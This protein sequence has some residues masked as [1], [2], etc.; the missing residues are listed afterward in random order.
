M[1]TPTP[2]SQTDKKTWIIIGGCLFVT[3]CLLCGIVLAVAAFFV[4]NRS[5]LPITMPTPTAVPTAIIVPTATPLLPTP[6]IHATP[7]NAP[8]PLPAT[9]TQPES[10]NLN[11]PAEVE[12]APIPELAFASLEQLYNGNY[13][14]YD[15]FEVAERL[16]GRDYGER[17][18]PQP[19]FNVGDKRMFVTDN[20]EHEATLLLATENAYFWAE[21]TLQLDMDK[22][23]QVADR[24]E[25]R[26][27]PQLVYLFGQEWRPGIDN[28]P[29]FNIMHLDTEGGS[30]L[31]YF[32]STDVYPKTLFSDSNEMEVIYLNMGNLSLGSE[33]YDGTLVHE[34]QHMI[35]WYVD[36]NET[37]W[38][39]E[40]LSQLAE[41]YLG[42][43]TADATDF[44]RKPDITVNHWNYD[45]DVVDAHYSA[46]YLFDVYFWEQLGDTA[47]Q[48]LAR[49]PANG[50]AAVKA[51]LPGYDTRSFEGFIAD[52]AA[53]NY[54]DSPDAGPAYN[55]ESLNLRAVDEEAILR[56]LPYD[57]TV[58]VGQFG[59]DYI[60]LNSLRGPMTLSFAG[61]TVIEL[62][63]APPPSGNLMWYVP[64][65][66][67]TGAV[68]EHTFDLSGV[69]SATLRF[70][71]WFDLEE[72]W[73][74][75]YVTISVDGGDSWEILVPDH[76][77]AG[78]FGPAFNG[79][80]AALRDASNGWVK[81]SIS[82]NRYVG[83]QV[84]IRFE[85][86]TDSA[87]TGRGFALDDIAIPEIGY[88]SSGENGPDGWQANGF[89]QTGWQIPQQW[90]VQL[91]EFGPNPQVTRFQLDA[92]NQL[93]TQLN[94]GKAGGVLAVTPI[95]SF[96]DQEAAYWLHIEQGQ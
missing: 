71:T 55:Y 18:V 24:L 44:L 93:V 13:P 34:I 85:V 65:M 6:E 10:F 62:T 76:A 74:F 84:I 35:Q 61:D 60:D 73:D 50:M 78:E 29:R 15:Y 3:A 19:Q 39:N 72:S 67:E 22:L 33:L 52:W 70:A 48:D 1:N 38:M 79:R 49:H 90:I 86:Y 92:R 7:E 2:S 53:A 37:T 30:E 77:E 23:Q 68:L 75:A 14:Y 43:D 8:S 5:I 91:I 83:Q 41:I 21:S 80:S 96:V 20:G 87:V 58:T 27:Y 94:I 66:D 4:F 64:P 56:S 17:I 95:T 45:D 47:V 51:I 9:P 89:V 42:L 31:G 28:D 12:Q 40:G 46:A 54:L 32:S 11:P 26:Y 57:E 25:T 82:L 63:D 81:E 36:P 16:S 59:T 69:S 88:E